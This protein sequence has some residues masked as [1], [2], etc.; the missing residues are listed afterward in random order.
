MLEFTEGAI[1]TLPQYETTRLTLA[2]FPKSFEGID[3]DQFDLIVF[4]VGNGELLQGPA[5][6]EIRAEIGETP[7]VLVSDHLENSQ[8]R[9]LFQ[10]N[11]KDWLRKPL[12][13]RSFL[14]AI[15]T[16][17]NT[18]K[19]GSGFVHAVVSAGG[20][21]GGTTVALTLA[22][23]L[24]RT[25]KRRKPRVA[26]FDLDFAAADCGAYL[27]SINPYDLESALDN[28]K[29]VDTEFIDLVRNQHEAGFSLFSFFKPEL[30][31]SPRT[32][33]LVLR[34]L[35][36]IAFQNDHTV[37]DLP[38]Y[39]TPWREKVISSVNSITIVTAVSIPA[40]Q[41]AK[42]LKSRIARLRGESRTVQ[43]I[44]NKAYGGGLFGS[45]LGS[46]EIGK[47]FKDDSFVIIQDERDVMMRA[48][49]HG[50]L[51]N[52]VSPRSKFD[53]NV[54]RLADSLREVG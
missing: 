39:E 11:G 35:D 37:L 18:V 29:R 7:L 16:H 3:T 5:L 41:S 33:E 38:Y 22:H 1:S 13:R 24:A 4:D 23:H 6:A 19:A 9:L 52:E 2:N 26:L 42:L 49:N 20:G 45:G 43:I 15:N 53:K 50:I 21:A 40:L 12:E 51:P 44:A 30:L 10:L 54:S 32:N 25:R 47:I 34:M 46:A 48:V 27:N 31:L 14:E 28:P 8:I 17:M 36:V